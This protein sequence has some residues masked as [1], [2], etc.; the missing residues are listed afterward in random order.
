MTDAVLIENL[1]FNYKRSAIQLISN[2]N[3]KISKG[4]RFGIFGPNG[5]GKTTLMNLMTG[6]LTYT[7]GSI[8]LLGNE[9]NNNRKKIKKLLGFV[10]QDFSFYHE[11]SPVE[12]MEF[13]GAW[14]GLNKKHIREKTDELLDFG[15]EKVI[16]IFTDTQK[17]MIAESEK[18]WRII[19]WEKDIIILKNITINIQSILSEF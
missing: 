16:W 5:A 4:D 2:L 17:V 9:I 19:D 18:D 6:L 7:S 8:Q 1:D 14:A 3:L 15:V 13:F 10:P 11:L 12:N